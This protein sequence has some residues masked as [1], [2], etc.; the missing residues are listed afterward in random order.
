MRAPLTTAH[1]QCVLCT[2]TTCVRVRRTPYPMPRACPRALAGT[3]ACRSP[4]SPPR[5]HS[6]PCG[7][8]GG[9]GRVCNSTLCMQMRAGRG[10]DGLLQHGRAA[11]R[12]GT[13][14]AASSLWTRMARSPRWVAQL[15]APS[16]A[17]CAR[18][19]GGE[20]CATRPPCLPLGRQPQAHE[21]PCS[22]RCAGSPHACT[23][24]PP[25]PATPHACRPWQPTMAS[26]RGQAASMRST[27]GR[28]PAV[29]CS[30]CVLPPELLS[31]RLWWWRGRL[32]H[33]CSR[34]ARAAVLL[35]GMRHW[36]PTAVPGEG[37]RAAAGQAHPASN[38]PT[39]RLP[40]LL[41][42]SRTSTTS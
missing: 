29:W 39:P 34:T 20:R 4:P 6:R 40:A 35:S 21:V 8:A 33:A 36:C 16:H 26:V 14:M 31:L 37:M 27:T 30:W 22:T 5:S 32:L 13:R 7:H 28:S 11:A 42:R 23:S 41:R 38:P 24:L 2:V 25:T 10:W 15:G 9:C 18:V 12:A 1:L 17:A 3:R 19:L